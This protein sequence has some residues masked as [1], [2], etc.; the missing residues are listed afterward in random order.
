MSYKTAKNPPRPSSTEHTQEAL[1]R[2]IRESGLTPGDA[3]PAEM[4][5][6]G[7][8]GVSRT[9][10]REVFSR[11]RLL[12]LVETRKR[13]GAVLRQPD[14]PAIFRLAFDPAFLP[15]RMSREL[16]ELRLTLEMGLPDLLFLRRDAI[17]FTR[18]EEAV[19]RMESARGEDERVRADIAFHA[20]LY[21]ATGNRTLAAF[22]QILTS[23]FQQVIILERSVRPRRR[24]GGVS[25]R[26]LLEV[27]RSGTTEAFRSAMRAHLSTHFRRVEAAGPAMESPGVEAR[28]VRG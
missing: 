15:P 22:Q 10:I 23:F 24:A 14:L 19:A 4:E 16:F 12:G 6:A 21:R 13:R 3:L 1:L 18:L 11:L 5:L 8:F 28:P 7:R 20:E 9:V 2:W 25:H 17:D 26:E 27:L